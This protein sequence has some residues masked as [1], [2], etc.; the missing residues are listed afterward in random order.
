MTFTQ[1]PVHL[2][3]SDVFMMEVAVFEEAP[4]LHATHDEGVIRTVII[5]QA[6]VEI[7]HPLQARHVAHQ[8][9]HHLKSEDKTSCY[10]VSFFTSIELDIDKIPLYPLK[11]SKLKN[12]TH[13]QVINSSFL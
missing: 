9:K 7:K 6:T 13:S 4:E 5:S 10:S 1:H 2:S 11:H 12:C 8:N 3:H